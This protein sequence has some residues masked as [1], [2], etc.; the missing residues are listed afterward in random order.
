MAV[1]IEG[2][3]FVSSR[4]WMGRAAADTLYDGTK[5][6]EFL[7]AV[8]TGA[9]AAAI[10]GAINVIDIDGGKVIQPPA[11]AAEFAVTGYLKTAAGTNGILLIYKTFT[12]DIVMKITQ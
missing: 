9:N 12:E 6:D 1:N 5:N 3:N 4:K 7:N 11:E 8:K 2:R 10:I